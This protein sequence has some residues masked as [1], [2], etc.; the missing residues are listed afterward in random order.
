MLLLLFGVRGGDAPSAAAATTAQLVMHSSSHS[1]AENKAPAAVR[2][3]VEVHLLFTR[4]S[5]VCS[6]PNNDS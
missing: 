1:V 2:R 3:V 6:L 4:G 5:H